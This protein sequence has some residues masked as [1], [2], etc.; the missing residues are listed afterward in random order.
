MDSDLKCQYDL[1][2]NTKMADNSINNDKNDVQ[3]ISKESFIHKEN[4]DIVN[5]KNNS[6]VTAQNHFL[7][8]GALNDMLQSLSSTVSSPPSTFPFM[9]S[10]WVMLTPLS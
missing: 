10:I 2:K 8:H 5:D 4:N 7:G 6:E 1:P 3:A 9:C